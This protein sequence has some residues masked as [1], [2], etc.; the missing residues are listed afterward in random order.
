MPKFKAYI[1]ELLKP[2]STLFLHQLENI[3]Y[4]SLILIFL[5]ILKTMTGK[6]DE[7]CMGYINT[8]NGNDC[9]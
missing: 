6:Y 7:L 3:M 4:V 2:V 9:G 8:M 1:N 5:M